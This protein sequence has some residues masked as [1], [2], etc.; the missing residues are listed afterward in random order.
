MSLDGWPSSFFVL[1]GFLEGWLRFTL[2][3]ELKIGL[4]IYSRWRFLY[5]GY[6]SRIIFKGIT[7]PKRILNLDVV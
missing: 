2:I 1:L 5:P 6:V 4:T 3:D 7:H